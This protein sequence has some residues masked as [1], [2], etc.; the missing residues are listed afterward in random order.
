M[1]E[2][3]EET[4]KSYAQISP[5]WLL[6]QED[7][8][9]PFIGA[10]T[11]EQLE[12]NLGGLGVERRADQTALGGERHRGRLPLPYDP[13]DAAGLVPGGSGKLIAWI[14]TILTCA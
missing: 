8:T 1:G 14:A 12:D 6:R 4:G 5:N 10:R 13:G 7:V 9:V 3:S 11:M 2:I